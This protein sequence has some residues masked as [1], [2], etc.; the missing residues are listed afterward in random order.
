MMNTQEQL[1]QIN[2]AI[3]AIENGAQSYKIGTM[4]VQRGDLATLYRERRL[5]NEQ[6]AQEENNGGTYVAVF[7]RR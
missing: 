5:L 1:Q 6:L 7:D 3:A 4:N 2:N